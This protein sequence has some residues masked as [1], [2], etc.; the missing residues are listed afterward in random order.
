MKVQHTILILAVAAIIGAIFYLESQRQRVSPGS[1]AGSTILIRSDT[2]RAKEKE[3]RG[4]AQAKEITTPDGFINTDGIT[5]SGLIGKKVAL[6]DFWTYSC[7]NCQR[8]TP[9]LNAWYE[10]YKDKG[11]EIIGVHTPEF[12]FE[13]KYENV[14]RAVQKFGIKYPVVLDNDYSTWYAYENNW[15]PHK[16][17]IDIDGF[18]VYD[19]IGEGA[20]EETE[21]RIQAALAERM[22]ALGEQGAVGADIATPTGVETPAAQSPEIYFGAQ[23]NTYLGNGTAQKAGVQ[24]FSEPKN[25][26]ANT[27]YL[28][29]TWDIQN[30]FASNASAPAKIAFRYRAKSVY[31]VARADAPVRIRVLLDGELISAAF[32]DDVKKGE[33]GLP[34]ISVQEDRLYTIVRDA[35]VAEHLLELIIEDPGLEAFTFTFG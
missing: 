19:H 16:Y 17:L 9:Y 34:T 7:I 35:G 33:L 29:G 3:S 15:W 18:I 13:K 27:L 6:I 12:D 10:K 22:T 21:R 28:V 5:V 20:Y 24:E 14:L 30:E 1:T 32:G 4:L 2:E 31:M 25:I 26:A 8:T 23:R 11:L